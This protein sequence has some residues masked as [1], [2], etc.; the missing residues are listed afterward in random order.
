MRSGNLRLGRFVRGRA[1]AASWAESA[2]TALA[3]L[4]SWVH[5]K[6]HERCTEPAGC[7]VTV[8]RPG[9]A[10]QA[11][12]EAERHEAMRAAE[13]VLAAAHAKHEA[14]TAAAA[15][16]GGGG[17]GGPGGAHAA[18]HQPPAQAL[19]CCCSLHTHRKVPADSDDE[20][21]LC[22]DRGCR[23]SKLLESVPGLERHPPAHEAQPALM[24]MA[25]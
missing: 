1:D 21:V 2:L 6:Q 17:G 8:L 22:Q 19:D 10:L 9:G 23:V 13:R 15:D 18:Q 3:G 5:C 12:R 11:E 16:D 14:D 24:L 4:T 20:F 7:Y 25:S